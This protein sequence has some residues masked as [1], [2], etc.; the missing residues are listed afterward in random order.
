MAKDGPNLDFV[1]TREL[2]NYIENISTGFVD[3]ILGPALNKPFTEPPQPLIKFKA[4]VQKGGRIAIPQVERT[5]NEIKDGDIVEVSLN[6][7][8][9][10]TLNI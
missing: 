8:R 7:V 4:I 3:K 1:K 9:R 2:A 5:I 10:N 6:S